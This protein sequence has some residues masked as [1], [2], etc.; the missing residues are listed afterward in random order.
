MQSDINFRFS[1]YCYHTR[2]SQFLI[3][4]ASCNMEI[5]APE[6]S[7]LRNQCFE[8]TSENDSNN[9]YIKQTILNSPIFTNIFPSF[10]V[11]INKPFR[12]LTSSSFNDEEYQVRILKEEDS[13]QDAFDDD[14]DDLFLDDEKVPAKEV[15]VD[16]VQLKAI[17]V[18]I[19]SKSILANG[20]EFST[21][22]EIRSSCMICGIQ[23]LEKGGEEDSLLISLKS[24][25]LLLIRFYYVPRDYKDTDYSFQTAYRVEQVGNSI[26]K[27]FI[28]QWWDTSSNLSIPTLETS[29]YSLSSHKWGLSVVSTSANKSFRIYNTQHTSTGVLFEKHFN[30]GVDGLI[31]HSCFAEPFDDKKVEN[32]SIFMTLVFTEFRRL[33][34]NLFS[35]SSTEDIGLSFAKSTLPLDNNFTVP[36]FVVPLGKNKGF[37][38]VCPEEL[39]I[40]TLHNVISAEYDF[41]RMVP[42]WKGISFPTTFHVLESP[43]R[44]LSG[45]KFDEVLISTD[46][47]IIYS[48]I[49]TESHI[50]IEPIVRVSD[51][52][53]VFSLEKSNSNYN[54]I[55]ASDTGSNKDLIIPQLFSEEYSRSIEDHLKLEY[56]NAK[57]FKD[58]K[59]WSPLLDIEIIDSFNS[60][61]FDNQSSQ[62]LWG[63]AG[64]G[65][66][67]KLT[68]FRHGFSASRRSNSYEKLRKAERLH[69]VTFNTKP[70]LFCSFPFE[71]ILLE[72][73]PHLQESFV[74]IDDVTFL[75]E[76]STLYVASFKREDVEF[77]FQVTPIGIMLSN[78]ADVQLVHHMENK[79]I[80]LCQVQ[81]NRLVVVTESYSEPFEIVMEVFMLNYSFDIDC[82]LQE[83][84]FLTPLTSTTLNFQPC[85]LKVIS[86]L[87]LL[88][89]GFD[90]RIY[91]YELNESKGTYAP[92][93]HDLV[94]LNPYSANSISTEFIIPNDAHKA[95]NS[96]YIGSK[97][98]YLIQLEL[99]HLTC[100]KFLRISETP[101]AF[102][103]VQNDEKL[104]LI[105]S[106]SLWLLNLYDSE[107]PV[108][109]HF[110]ET[111]ERLIR[112]MVEIPNVFESDNL[113]KYFAF[114]RDDGLMIASVF[115]FKEP[116]IRQISIS[117][118]AKKLSY[119]SHLSIFALLCKSKNPRNRIRF[120][121]RKTFKLMSHMEGSVKVRDSDD[122]I[123][124]KNEFPACA[125]IWSIKRNNKTSKKVLIGSGILDSDLETGSFKVLDISKSR[126]HHDQT[127]TIKVIELTSFE[128]PE[129]ITTICQ[130]ESD[131]IFASGKNIWGTTYD[132]D[133]KRL[134]PVTSLESLPS[135]IVSLSVE[136]G[137]KLWITT[138]LDS[139]FQYAYSTD[140]YGKVVLNYIAS[141]PM[142][143]SFVNQ[144]QLRSKVVAGDKLHSAISI[145]DYDNNKYSTRVSYR[146]AS[147]PRVYTSSFKCCWVDSGDKNFCR[148][149]SM[150]LCIGVNGEVT[151]IR[152][153]PQ[154]GL[155]LNL[156]NNLLNPNHANFSSLDLQIE[157]L[158]RPFFNKVSGTGLLSLNKPSFDFKSNRGILIDYDLEELSKICPTIICI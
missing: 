112:A 115:T 139:I 99:P 134:K 35:W 141:D 108:K 44:G 45:S 113:R 2:E 52:I 144:A 96:L 19:K 61:S 119:F 83:S 92:T 40:V 105:H 3:F 42:P 65:K 84:G 104:I 156:V 125:C 51:S 131:I 7:N 47:G 28:V 100:K 137:K 27:P 114:I 80:L 123:F 24:G 101:V 13:Q 78:L 152:S 86:P 158:E 20:I 29:G 11:R 46:S 5:E 17:Q 59:K 148:H 128:H 69:F 147:I 140:E 64:A 79:S 33:V 110:D 14:D 38:F 153:V 32:H 146:M 89:G 15:D 95:G 21:K 135:E 68:H 103:K 117:D 154:D 82:A 72:L 109:V 129:P 81:D 16:P 57:K 77:I 39:V 121:D 93:C 118:N 55:Y 56:T 74:E 142:P 98:G 150:V 4:I 31:L 49:V 97:D 10:D 136:D 8:K 91:S 120:V 30:V 26:F 60:K 111:Y 66:R 41:R 1:G 85:M 75:N 71:T 76:S 143:N 70:Y 149:K 127:S 22:T 50:S 36:V 53:S 12:G 106:K 133:E 124:S 107:F 9:K 43:L 122:S 155:E 73:Q 6:Y 37:L 132:V 88:I 90:G 25:F 102:T 54:L 18:I 87:N 116:S 34:I 145:I 157:K 94:S 67:T 151:A 63:I 48:V 126:P 23:D 62:E 130:I 58:Y 138:K